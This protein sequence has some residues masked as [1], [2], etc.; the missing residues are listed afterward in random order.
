MFESSRVENETYSN[1]GLLRQFPESLK[2][3]ITSLV[4]CN[5]LWRREG[6]VQSL[7]Y[8]KRKNTF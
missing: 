7:V 1:E 6:S 8:R 5:K 2:V 3:T 4:D